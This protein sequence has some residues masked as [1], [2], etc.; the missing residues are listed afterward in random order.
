MSDEGSPSGAK[1]GI[2]A[3]VAS[4]VP[5]EIDSDIE[6]NVGEAS[7]SEDFADGTG[8]LDKSE[9]LRASQSASGVSGSALPSARDAAPAEDASYSEDFA[10]GTGTFGEGTMEEKQVEAEDEETK[11]RRAVEERR[12][13]IARRQEADLSRSALAR[14][15]SREESISDDNVDEEIPSDDDFDVDEDEASGSMYDPDAKRREEEKERQ[16]REREEEE[17]KRRLEAEEAERKRREDEANKKLAAE[18]KKKAEEEER[19]RKAEEEERRKKAE[20][21]ERKRQAEEAERKKKAEEEERKRKAEEEERRKKAEEEERERQAEEEERKKNAQEEERKR[22]EEEANNRKKAEEEERKRKAEEEER[23]KKAEEEERERQAEEEERKKNAQEEERKRQ[24]EEA[25]NRKKA[26]EEE[27]KRKAEEEERRKKAEEEERKRKAEEEEKAKKAEEES[28][29]MKAEEEERKRQAEQEE[30]RKRTEEE[31]QKRKAEDEERKVKAEEERRQKLEEEEQ[32]RKTEE[33]ERKAKA[34]EERKRQAEQDLKRQADEERKR[35][36]AE[37]EEKERKRKAEDERNKASAEEAERKWQA[38]Q[39]DLRNKAEEEQ[40]HEEDECKRRAA[41]EERKR[42]VMEEELK[43]KAEE[44]RKQKTEQEE[45]R[46]RAGA[47]QAQ[48]QYKWRIDEEERS[49]KAAASSARKADEQERQYQLEGY[50]AKPGDD[51]E[52]RKRALNQDDRRAWNRRQEEEQRRVQASEEQLWRPPRPESAARSYRA[53]RWRAEDEV[54]VDRQQPRPSRSAE[55]AGE[56]RLPL[57]RRDGR[58]P[59]DDASLPTRRQR[60]SSH[61]P[62]EEDSDDRDDA[63]SE[64]WW[65]HRRASWGTGSG[66][67]SGRRWR[68]DWSRQDEKENYWLGDGNSPATSSKGGAAWRSNSAN[69]DDRRG[70]WHRSWAGDGWQSTPQHARSA[71]ADPWA[72]SHPQMG[73]ALPPH[74]HL[75]LFGWPGRPM[76]SIPPW[77]QC[78]P[79]SCCSASPLYSPPPQPGPFGWPSH[80]HLGTY[81]PHH[82]WSPHPCHASPGYVLP[83][84]WG[85]PPPLPSAGTGQPAALLI[86]PQQAQ[87]HPVQQSHYQQPPQQ[88]YQ[89]QNLLQQEQVPQQHQALQ[90][91]SPELPDGL[92]H[93]RSEGQPP[94]QQIRPP[95]PKAPRPRPEQAPVA[96]AKDDQMFVSSASQTAAG[97][98]EETLWPSTILREAPGQTIAETGL[99][100]DAGSADFGE[101]LVGAVAA[102]VDEMLQLKYGLGI[103]VAD[104]SEKLLS[105]D[106]CELLTVP[107][108][109]AHVNSR[110]DLWI[111]DWRQERQLKV[112]LSWQE[113][114][115]LPELRR[116][117]RLLPGTASAVAVVTV[118]GGYA[119]DA[120]AAFRTGCSDGGSAVGRCCRAGAA[121]PLR[122]FNTDD[123]CSAVALEPTVLTVRA[124]GATGDMEQAPAVTPEYVALEALLR[125]DGEG[126]GLSGGPVVRGA[127][128]V[129]PPGLLA[130]LH[131]VLPTP[132][133]L[134]QAAT[135]LERSDVEG[136]AV[137]ELLRKLAGWFR[138]AEAPVVAA[139]RRSLAEAPAH[140]ALV[141]A[142]RRCSGEREICELGCQVLGRASRHHVENAAAFVSCGAAT[143]VCRMLE[144]H[145]GS[146]ELQRHGLYALGCLSHYGGGASQSTA[147]GAVGLAFRAMSGHR[148][149]PSVQINS[150]EVLRCL[151]ELGEAPMDELAEAGQS[152]KR[153]FPRDAAVHRAADLLLSLAVPRSAASI[154]TLMDSSPKEEAVQRNG[155]CSLG[156]LAGNGGVAWRGASTVAVNRILRAMGHHQGSAELQAV[157]LWALGRFAERVEAPEAGMQDAAERAKKRHANSALV[158]RQADQL[159]AYLMRP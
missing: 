96:S 127:S 68:A 4:E 78:S 81:S 120:V 5:S 3:S 146:K 138:A 55:T 98:E 116:R 104:Y 86:P 18:R 90:S 101:S 2:T 94:K 87:P 111:T 74:G 139:A 40:K 115:G 114:Q 107:R 131:A 26:E 92:Q 137:L 34:E 155:I 43:T 150:C 53:D 148:S 118:A 51:E 143:E 47:E 125:A 58:Q 154:G 38:Q 29:K 1:V 149:S 46:K 42:K 122:H 126:A 52:E 151:A 17:K 109:A 77:P 32:K 36:Q 141:A 95:P 113:L 33:E 35:E 133:V 70:L 75:S 50:G 106:A 145:S 48:Q 69:R 76:E 159:I 91:R 10:E 54:E 72:R 8:T 153:A 21:A 37:E 31:E 41:E 85:P 12:L 158:C 117:L 110:P 45:L 19:K 59:W 6:E 97:N 89:Q 67:G 56:L 80:S 60:A 25:N 144:R 130:A 135:A 57:R 119:V 28:M 128:P 147:A 9:Q 157:G 93:P 49:M 82:A 27:R 134:R 88:G 20:E 102:V 123:L 152:A 23:R 84:A 39:E 140:V 62:W 79:A 61:G 103:D 124:L 63:E 30:L 22:Q 129:M 7:Y 99:L 14:S 11:R 136:E 65:W 71:S 15:A 105:I 44:E 24:E 83:H 66:R 64:D 100:V 13:E 16:Q 132:V 156:H 121:R 108:L 112:R 73:E 142:L